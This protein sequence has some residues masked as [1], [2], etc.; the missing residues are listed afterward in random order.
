MNSVINHGYKMAERILSA[1]TVL[2]CVVFF[3]VACLAL[4]S[5]AL[6]TPLSLIPAYPDISA[7]GITVTYDHSMEILTAIG[8]PAFYK[9]D[10][11]PAHAQTI[12]GDDSQFS[13]YLMIDQYGAPHG[14]TLTITGS[15]IDG[16]STIPLLSGSL[17]SVGF[18]DGGGDPLEFLFGNLSGSLAPSFSYGGAGVILSFTGFPS[19]TFGQDFSNQGL[20][21]AAD[22]FNYAVPEPGTLVLFA[23]GIII[24][25]FIGRRAMISSR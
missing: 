8:Y 16:G 9:P 3:A 23:S 12:Y 1:C 14:G 19:S 15:F 21:G 2:S 20:F 7:S 11:D 6:A 4:P 25:I 22:T 24:M 17:L 5:S 13:M 18:L 10:A